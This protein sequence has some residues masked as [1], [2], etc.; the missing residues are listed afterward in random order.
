M[1]NKICNLNQFSTALWIN[2]GLIWLLWYYFIYNNNETFKNLQP[3][4]PLTGMFSM[5]M[6][7]EAHGFVVY[8]AVRHFK[9][10]KQD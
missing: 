3:L 7:A 8:R 10:S 4:W 6:V 1:N 2:F 5:A 9:N